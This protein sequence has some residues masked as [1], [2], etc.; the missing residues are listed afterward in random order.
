MSERNIKRVLVV[1][2]HPI[3]RDGIVARV[4]R[5]PGFQVE[6]AVGSYEEAVEALGSAAP[7]DLALV[8]LSLPGK[9][10][11]ALLRHISRTRPGLRSLVVSLHEQPVYA[12]RALAEGASGYVKKSEASDVLVQAIRRVMEGR[13]FVSES[14]AME[15][16]GSLGA[17]QERWD[18]LLSTR[19]LE[20]FEL[21]G[22]GQRPREIAEALFL[23]VKTVESHLSN[24]RN[25]LG[26]RDGAELT[27]Q[28]IH[29]VASQTDPDGK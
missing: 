22:S 8:D 7:F 15:L 6:A 9:G 18:T 27:F 19:E 25:K 29:W 20:I 24:I 10:G 26:L 3:V 28:A 4:N 2:D 5:I 13:V 16:L 14:I 1:D 23:S 21:I 11:L 17:G 12:E